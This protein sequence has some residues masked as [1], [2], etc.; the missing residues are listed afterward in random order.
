MQT[1]IGEAA[2]VAQTLRDKLHA[3]R[4]H[5]PLI[6]A[7]RRPGLKERHWTRISAAVGTPLRI[8]EHFSLTTALKLGLMD[9]LA[10][11]EAEADRA[12]KEYALERGIERMQVRQRCSLY[13]ILCVL[14]SVGGAH[15]LARCALRRCEFERLACMQA[16]WVGVKLQ[17]EAWRST[18]TTVLCATDDLQALLDDH[19]MQMKAV[20]ASPF[21]RPIEERCRAWEAKLRLLQVR[22]T[23]S[24][25]DWWMRG[26]QPECSGRRLIFSQ[27]ILAAWLRCQ[28]GW[29]HLEPVF[30][31]DD[32]S[33]QM[34]NEVRKFRA[35]D[36]TWRATMA[37][38]QKVSDALHVAADVELLRT[39]QDANTL[40]DQVWPTS[41]ACLWRL[42]CT[43]CTFAP[44]AARRG[45]AAY[46]GAIC[47]VH[48][49]LL[50]ATGAK[51]PQRVP[52]V[53]APALPSLLLSLGQRA[54]VRAP[55]R[56]G[57]GARAALSAQDL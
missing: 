44:T 14:T 42:L 52:R 31:G 10:I 16:D 12:S 30:L 27:E 57:P 9:H 2:S 32:V 7:L 22:A 55:R 54:P 26:R 56:R 46:N 38:L 34:P 11:I 25:C 18:G 4:Q 3:F 20:R 43:N 28:H 35:V 45:S 41:S 49:H 6:V 15:D 23:P 21:I 40:I 39:L 33:Q 48:R 47:T 37:K 53:K 8:D 50:V 17:A 29:V 5:V 13:L 36:T 51:G 1:I 24:T 19:V